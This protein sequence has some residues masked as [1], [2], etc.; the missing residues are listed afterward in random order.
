MIL[1]IFGIKNEINPK[2][3]PIPEIIPKY[4]SHEASKCIIPKRNKRI[5]KAIKIPKRKFL[6]DLNAIEANEN[7]IP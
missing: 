6:N 5:I 4:I 3:I 1:K 7:V 2:N